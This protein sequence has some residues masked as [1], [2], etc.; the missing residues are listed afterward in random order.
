M[1]LLGGLTFQP[2]AKMAAALRRKVAVDTIAAVTQSATLPE[3]AAGWQDARAPW[4]ASLNR[5]Q[6]FQ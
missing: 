6:L 4:L 5:T 1:R 2:T 3:N